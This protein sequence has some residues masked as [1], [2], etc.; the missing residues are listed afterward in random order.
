MCLWSSL[1]DSVSALGSEVVVSLCLDS[2]I[3]SVRKRCEILLEQDLVRVC[4]WER[5]REISNVLLCEKVENGLRIKTIF[6]NI[7][8]EN[9][10][11]KILD[12]KKMT[13]STCTKSEKIY[14]MGQILTMALQLRP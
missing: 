6:L 9:K 8:F 4:V 3:E 11:N 7:D 12:F 5:E 14:R 13:L 10:K 2:G 1:R